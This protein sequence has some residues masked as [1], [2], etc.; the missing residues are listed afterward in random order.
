MGKVL[1]LTAVQAL[2]E[3]ALRTCWDMECFDSINED[4]E[5]RDRWGLLTVPDWFFDRMRNGEI[6]DECRGGGA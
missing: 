1:D 5:S 3:D 4:F 2:Y 6:V